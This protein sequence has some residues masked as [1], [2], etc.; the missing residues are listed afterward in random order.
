MFNIIFTI[1]IITFTIM[2]STIANSGGASDQ[3]IDCTGCHSTGG[4]GLL[5][6]DAP[7]ADIEAGSSGVIISMK[8]NLDNSDGVIAGVMLLD[9]EG[10]VP[11]TSG[12]AIISDP[13]GNPQNYNYNEK[14]GISGLT[15][16]DWTLTAPEVPG[17]YGLKARM[18]FADGGPHYM[19]TDEITITV[20]DAV[21]GDSKTTDDI[22]TD[23]NTT[24]NGLETGNHDLLTPVNTKGLV[25]GVLV[26]LCSFMM[27][28]ILRRRYY[29]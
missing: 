9:G 11:S 23:N 17:S 6:I 18:M 15:T 22:T 1:S 4:N 27:I 21:P 25:L 7:D 20:L 14:S 24:T 3:N 2:G 12:W 8:V 29:E 19:E 13:N 26:G 5:T 28:R 10:K 16:F